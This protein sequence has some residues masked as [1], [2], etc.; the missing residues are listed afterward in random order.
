M[1]SC[2]YC[3]HA[4]YVYGNE[5]NCDKYKKGECDPNKIKLLEEK[6]E[7]NNDGIRW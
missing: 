2:K 3:K 4:Y 7:E 6:K 5:W 1:E